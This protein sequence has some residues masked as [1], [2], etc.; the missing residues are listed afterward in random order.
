ML[1]VSV[2]GT[3]CSGKTTISKRIAD[4]HQIPHIELDEIFWQP[5]WTP[6]PVDQFRSAVQALVVDEA[7]VI[8]GVYG[9]V[10]DI[11]WPH[12][13]DVIWMNL[14]LATVLWRV[15]RRTTQ[16]VVTREKLFAGNRE[17]LGK[18]MS[19]KESLIW[20]VIRTHQGRIRALRAELAREQYSHLNLHEITM[21]SEARHL[22]Q[23]GI[24]AG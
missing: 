8:D 16:R 20:W 18:A 4:E 10:R 12:A 24:S 6:M 13:T 17:T 1:R 11:V 9:K 21:S 5:N 3:S 2:I 15:I 19:S 7:W 22:P 14:P 23:L